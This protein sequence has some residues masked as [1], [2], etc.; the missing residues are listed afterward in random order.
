M[1]TRQYAESDRFYAFRD[2]VSNEYY[3]HNP[4]TNS[5]TWTEPSGADI[6]D[7]VTL[8]P[9]KFAALAPTGLIASNSSGNIP[10][11]DAPFKITRRPTVRR[12][13]QLSHEYFPE[14][15]FCSTGAR[16]GKNSSTLCQLFVNEEAE[17]T[18]HLPGRT[19][20]DI[21]IYFPD[22]IFSDQDLVSVTDWARQ[23]IC[24]R[25]SS[26]RKKKTPVTPES[27]LI[28][29][30]N[31]S[32]IPLLNYIE[33]QTKNAVKIFQ[34]AL[35][36]GKRKHD[37]PIPFYVDI[38]WNNKEL[39]DEAFVQLVKL[40]TNN[41]NN[42]SLFRIWELMVILCSLFLPGPHVIDYVK[43]F[44]AKVALASNKEA[45][46]FAQLSYLRLQ[47]RISTEG[48]IETLPEPFILSGYPGHVN[49]CRSIMGITLWELMWRQRR[50]KPRMRV[51]LFL[52]E[53]LNA[54]VK[55]GA[56][57]SPDTFTYPGNK[58][59]IEEMVHELDTGRDVFTTSTLLDLASLFKKWIQKLP[60]TLVPFELQ[61]DII[62]QKVGKDF[63][64]LVERLGQLNKDVL[65]Y[66][67]G[68]LR[69]YVKAQPTTRNVIGM[70]FGSTFIRFDNSN[71]LKMKVFLGLATDF[72]LSLID[73][74]DVSYVYPLDESTLVQ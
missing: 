54:L 39:I 15:M 36:Y 21:P 6:F 11:I 66:L 2:P 8:E 71:P 49:E 57:D 1:D 30:D 25:K 51:P 20:S 7:G 73:N 16:D 45:A 32:N 12:P 3:F 69:D 56:M 23:Y 46:K 38:I 33:K 10:T 19:V 17:S 34:Y 72:L 50:D 47:A 22:S 24:V 55:K 67:V 9:F 63:L 53:L 41:P 68:F 31:V 74:W 42:E 28:F 59:R 61:E 60:R 43:Q 4:I 5:V 70:T 44:L 40:M 65:A 27:L 58:K 13:R 35:A 14:S 52:Y 62:E 64:P 37:K 48:C 29:D 26:S 18:S